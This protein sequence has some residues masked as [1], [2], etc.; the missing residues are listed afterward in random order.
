[1]ESYIETVKGTDYFFLL[2]TVQ[3]IKRNS[4]ILEKKIFHHATVVK[5]L[6]GNS[7]EWDYIFLSLYEEKK[8]V[9]GSEFDDIDLGSARFPTNEPQFD[10][11]FSSTPKM[12]D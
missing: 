7:S 8:I 6:K 10:N 5:S 2:F 12:Y 11:T 1:M 9:I 4:F 3:Y